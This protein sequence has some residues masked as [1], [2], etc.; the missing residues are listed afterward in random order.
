M[1]FEFQFQLVKWHEIM[2]EAKTIGASACACVPE[3]PTRMIKWKYCMH[4]QGKDGE[5]G[6]D[7]MERNNGGD[8]VMTLDGNLTFSTWPESGKM[9]TRIDQV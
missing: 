8:V 1:L 9:Y 3:N 4:A 6:E 7:G 2:S 5:K